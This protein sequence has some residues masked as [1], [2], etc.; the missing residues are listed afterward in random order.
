[1]S[2]NSRFK[3]K[4]KVEYRTAYIGEAALQISEIRMGWLSNF[5]SELSW[6][7]TRTKH[8]DKDTIGESKLKRVLNTF[9]ITALGVGATLG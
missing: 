8:I 3:G 9:D 4:R 2:V 1:M 6:A 7:L 5:V